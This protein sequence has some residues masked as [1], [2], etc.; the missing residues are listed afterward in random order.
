MKL[1]YVQV[2][3]NEPEKWNICS[4]QLLHMAGPY[5]CPSAPMHQID[6]HMSQGFHSLGRTVTRYIRCES[7]EKG[8]FFQTKVYLIKDEKNYGNKA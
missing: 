6:K 5:D 7:R 4:K 1:S 3:S 2:Q 8:V